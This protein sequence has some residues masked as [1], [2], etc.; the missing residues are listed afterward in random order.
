[1]RHPLGFLVHDEPTEQVLKLLKGIQAVLD[2][3]AV[4]VSD[5]TEGVSWVCCSGARGVITL[6]ERARA[7]DT[8][9]LLSCSDIEEPLQHCVPKRVVT[10][11]DVFKQMDKRHKKR[12]ANIQS[13]YAKQGIALLE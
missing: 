13:H 7:K 5:A 6:E 4:I 3:G 11:D 10:R 8:H 9:P 2:S 1:M 12:L